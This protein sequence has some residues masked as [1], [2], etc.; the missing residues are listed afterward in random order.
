MDSHILA[1]EICVTY[2]YVHYGHV[3]Q[4]HLKNDLSNGSVIYR[5]RV[6]NIIQC[7]VRGELTSTDRCGH[8]TCVLSY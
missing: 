6:G 1:G 5:Y 8:C 4:N 3:Y 7:R 2:R